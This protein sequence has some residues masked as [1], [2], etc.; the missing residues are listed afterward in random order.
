[1]RL[2]TPSSTLLLLLLVTGARAAAGTPAHDQDPEPPL[3]GP[4]VVGAD[5][6]SPVLPYRASSESGTLELTEIAGSSLVVRVTPVAADGA[7][8]GRGRV[9]VLRS[10]ETR[11]V[12]L[13]DMLPL[14]DAAG[15]DLLIE[16]LGGSGRVRVEG[17]WL[18]PRDLEAT[19]TPVPAPHRHLD[20]Q[21]V[22]TSFALID[23]A[24][25]G[26]QLDHETAVLDRVYAIFG[27]ARLPAQLRGDDGDVFES[28]YLTTVAAE[29][30]SYSPTT[31]AAL[32]PF[33][34][35]PAYSGSWAAGSTALP[36]ATTRAPFDPCGLFSPLWSFKENPSG[37]VRVWYS[38]SSDAGVA[39]AFANFTDDIVWPLLANLMTPHVPI[40]DAAVSCNGGSDRLDI[41]LADV[42]R[43]FALT[44]TSS[45][46]H[47]A[48]FICLNR[49]EKPATL[50]HELFHAFQYSYQL[51]GCIKDAAYDWWTEGG[52]EW[53][54]DYVMPSDNS[55]HGAAHDYLD[56]PEQSL[57]VSADPRVYGTYLL[58]FFL[59]RKSGDASF[60]RKAW[61]DCAG[62]SAVYALDAIIPGGFEA[63]WPDFAVH[64]WNEK[65]AD[66]YFKWDKVTD[67][68]PQRFQ[69]VKVS[70]GSGEKEYTISMDLPG[71]SATYANYSFTDPSVRSVAFW[72][73]ASFDLEE[74]QVDVIGPF[75]DPKTA[76]A[77]ARKGVKVQAIVEIEG[78][79]PHV[80]DWTEKPYVTYCRDA[81]EERLR[82]LVIVISNSD[83]SD[84]GRR[85]RPQG[86]VP[87]LSAS[88]FG[89]WR[90]SGTSTYT[91]VANDITQTDTVDPVVWTRIGGNQPPP[92]IRYLPTG[93][94]TVALTGKC[95]G[96]KSAPL[97]GLTSLLTTYNYLPETSAARRSYKGMGVEPGMLSGYQCQ[98]GSGS[99]FIGGWF[100]VPPPQPPQPPFYKV[101]GDGAN[102]HATYHV[103]GSTWTWDLHAD[104]Q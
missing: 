10:R 51:A 93:T 87:R 9:V 1:M 74:Q 40:P 64:C 78:H 66:D 73:G 75:W 70:A 89:C 71:L 84:Q 35:P 46:S 92:S 67:S 31:R 76:S 38:V 26:G 12:R 18:R 39:A 36:L 56:H 94:V 8:V 14:A 98:G 54:Q 103:G 49:A 21:R 2:R 69:E 16:T 17:S 5:Q 88:N 42:P 3:D 85:A 80:E 100:L 44:L 96:S 55:E 52:A 4:P 45:C 24:E 102:L 58:P 97:S 27:D 34:V 53:A 59:F 33:L 90:W 79:D 7:P 13:G 30:A 43:S 62:V 83:F 68:P 65:P 11:R 63:V 60:V 91:E 41:Y 99:T 25:A 29:L 82:R 61:E 20:G 77:D 6:R 104:R 15:N 22:P 95:N 81:T 28:L 86:R 101:S 50:V 72:N 47:T 48:C 23:Q 32:Q 37:H 57:D 19:P